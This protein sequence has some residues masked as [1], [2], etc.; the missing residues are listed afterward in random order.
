TATAPARGSRPYEG[1]AMRFGRLERIR[2]P[3]ENLFRTL[4]FRLTFWNT[5]TILLLVLATLFGLRESIR[6][7]LLREFETALADDL[8]EVRNLL[9]RY[10][11]D[12]ERIKAEL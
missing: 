10:Y 7:A 2:R 1:A 11:P 12:W 4:R 6:I 9:K 8:V 3:L 5:G